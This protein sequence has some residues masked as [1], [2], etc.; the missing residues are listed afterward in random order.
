VRY[1][2]SDAL[3][4]ALPYPVLNGYVGAITVDP[5]Q[6]GDFQPVAL[7]ELSEGPHFWYAMQ[8]FMFAGIGLLGIAVFIRSD[9][10]QRRAARQLARVSAVKVP[11]SV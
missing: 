8:W 2:N 5:P 10:R 4:A 9:V 6:T 1:I 11:T 7:P 3:A